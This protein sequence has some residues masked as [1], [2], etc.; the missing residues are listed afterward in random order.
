MFR[1]DGKVALV[2]GASGGIG[3]AIAKALIAQ[4]AKVVLSGTRKNILK[5]VQEK[6]GG[7]EKTKIQ[8]ANLTDSES[9]AAL[10]PSSEELFGAPIDILVNNAGLTRDALALRMKGADWQ[11]VLDVDLSVPFKLSQIA[12]KGMMRRRYGRIINIASIVGVTGNVG[13]ANYSAAK[14]G[15]IGM[16]KSL[17]LEI[18]SRGITVNVVA[19]GFIETAMTD[20]LSEAQR[21]KLLE[22]I[23][24]GRMGKVEDIAAAVTYLASDEAQWITG[25]TLH[26]NGGMVMI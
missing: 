22:Q 14:A 2:T 26:V 3:Q 6:L 4:G 7:N 25:S 21:E 13:Q 11:T 9:V 5:E 16:S 18:S 12:I 8:V 20:Q 23:P 19:P 1:L 24:C 10:I 15:L 17:A